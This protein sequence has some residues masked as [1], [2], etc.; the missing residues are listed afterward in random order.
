MTPERGQRHLL[1]VDPREPSK[2]RTVPIGVAPDVDAL[3]ADARGVWTAD[4]QHTVVRVDPEGGHPPAPIRVDGRPVSIA[5]A[6]DSKH[7]WVVAR[8]SAEVVAIAVE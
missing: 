1:R 6:R 5:I 3:A 8:R 4:G 2:S 7:V